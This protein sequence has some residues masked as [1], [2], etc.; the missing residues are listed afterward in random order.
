MRPFVTLRADH[1]QP[2]AELVVFDEVARQQRV[3]EL[4]GKDHHPT[5][6]GYWEFKTRAG[7]FAVGFFSQVLLLEAVPEEVTG[8]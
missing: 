6:D 1:V 2:G 4:A 8:E 7:N 3:V 5:L